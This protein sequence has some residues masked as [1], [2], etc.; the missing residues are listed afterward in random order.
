MLLLVLPFDVYQLDRLHYLL[1]LRMLCNFGDLLGMLHQSKRDTWFKKVK[2]PCSVKL[3]NRR[4]LRNNLTT[5]A[6]EQTDR[7]NKPLEDVSQET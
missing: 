3:I 5:I 7:I 2:L 6:T 4:H 1:H